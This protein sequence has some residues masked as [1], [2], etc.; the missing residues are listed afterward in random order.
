MHVSTFEI[1]YKPITPPL[2]PGTE[3]I[4]RR[5]LQ[6]YFLTVANLEAV[7][8]L[9]RI[10]FLITLPNPDNPSRR[11][12]TN[13]LFISDVAAPDNVFSTTLSRVPAGGNRY[14]TFFTVPAGKT[15][16]VV[17]LPNITVPNFFV[18]VPSDIEIRGHVVLGLPCVFRRVGNFF[19]YGPQ[20][21]APASVLLNAEHRSTYLPRDW[22]ATATGRLDFDQTGVGITLASGRALN[23]VPNDSP[24]LFVLDDFTVDSLE[25]VL[26]RGVGRLSGLGAKARAAAIISDLAQLDPGRANL[27]AMNRLL[28]GLGIGIRV[29]P[30]PEGEKSAP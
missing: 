15:A 11:L 24:C 7:D 26:E 27:E 19:L 17:L 3:A 13:A 14:I 22:P 9:F 1:L 21:G 2:G 16:L 30:A 6:G 23:H 18:D 20:E 4:G 12:D 25:G 29:Q 8:F 28:E 10:E 5:V